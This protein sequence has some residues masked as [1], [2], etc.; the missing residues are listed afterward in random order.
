MLEFT[1]MLASTAVKQ[2]PV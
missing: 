1:S 2:R